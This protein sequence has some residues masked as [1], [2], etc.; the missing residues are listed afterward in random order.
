MERDTLPKRKA[1]RLKRF[2]YDAP[3]CYFVTICTAR[4]EPLFGSIRS[5]GAIHESPVVYLSPMG[6]IVE[7]T[8]LSLPLRFPALIVDQYVVMPNHIHLILRILEGSS[9]AKRG[10]I[11]ESPLRPS[12]SLYS[13]VIGYL[14][15]AASKEIHRSVMEDILIWQRGSYDY[16][17]RD[18]TDFQCVWQYIH[19][20]PQKWETDCYYIKDNG[21]CRI[22]SL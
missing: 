17:I 12:R 16:I 13:K 5:V 9:D 4:K 8:I 1:L 19:T 10:A 21:L 3:G 6:Q 2:D 18:E 20:N 22:T 15:A 11:H 14:K 7:Q